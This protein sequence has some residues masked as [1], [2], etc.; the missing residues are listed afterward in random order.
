MGP[1]MTA[2]SAIVGQNPWKPG[3]GD[4][5]PVADRESDAGGAPI[6]LKATLSLQ[7]SAVVAAAIAVASTAPEVRRKCASRNS[8]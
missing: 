3:V 6:P 7:Q 8:Q 4:V 2:S 5:D 1:Y